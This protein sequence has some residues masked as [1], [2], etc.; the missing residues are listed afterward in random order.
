MITKIIV[1]K[2]EILRKTVFRVNAMDLIYIKPLRFRFADN[3]L[4]VFAT[5]VDGMTG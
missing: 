5:D 4:F 2:L 1:S 3:D